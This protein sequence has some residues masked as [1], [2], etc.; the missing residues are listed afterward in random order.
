MKST[1]IVRKMDELGRIVI[2]VELRRSLDIQEK[3][4]MEILVDGERIILQK[5]VPSC[6]CIFCGNMD[7]TV[8]ING[9]L[10]C[11]KCLE[12]IKNKEPGAA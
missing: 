9:K 10:V 7:D 11:K 1:G 6:A 5:Y 3:D 2:P 4:G 12:E 8:S